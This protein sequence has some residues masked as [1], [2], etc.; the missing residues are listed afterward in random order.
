MR[1]ILL[2]LAVISVA[3]SLH[4]QVRSAVASKPSLPPCTVSGRVVTTAEGSPLK[5]TYIIL[6]EEHGGNEPRTYGAVSDAD[7]RFLLKDVTPGRYRFSASRTGYVTQHY[8]SNGERT[9]AVLDLR[10]GQEVTDVLFRM[11]RAA[12]ISGRINDEDGEPMANIRVSALRTRSQEEIEDEGPF[13]SRKRDLIPTA[14]A[15]TDDR[16][17]YRMFGIRPGEYYVRATDSP[18]PPRGIAE[19][20]EEFWARQDLGT[21][22]API[23][24]PGVLQLS[25][26]E[27]VSVSAGEETQ[28]DFTMRHVIEYSSL[29][30]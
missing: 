13:A 18:E 9:G 4:P 21:Q 15:Q 20:G 30:R 27:V 26:A 29:Q 16:G 23:Y 17:Q 1:Y 2:A 7:G 6:V 22:Y 5:S 28:I 11:T 19:V 24:Y 8:G 10:P 12:V 3:P 14:V 25:Q